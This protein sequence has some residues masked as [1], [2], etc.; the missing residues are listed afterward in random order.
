M[1][2]FLVQKLHVQV[3]S[4]VNSIYCTAIV[5]QNMDFTSG[6]FRFDN[7]LEVSPRLIICGRAAQSV[8]LPSVHS[9]PIIRTGPVHCAGAPSPA[10]QTA[11]DP[12]IVGRQQKADWCITKE[13]RCKRWIG[14]TMAGQLL[15]ILEVMAQW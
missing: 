4:Y 1:A 9:S 15:A 5:V 6:I 12:P 7:C 14:E 13:A 8:M 10:C 3:I 11:G 2:V